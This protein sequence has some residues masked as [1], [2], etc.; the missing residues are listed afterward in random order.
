MIPKEKFKILMLEKILILSAILCFLPMVSFSQPILENESMLFYMN[1][2]LR[3]DIVTFGNVVGLDNK[4]KDDRSTYYGI[5]YSL[6][7]GL[8]FKKSATKLYLKLER[9]GPYDYDAP[10]FVH[11]TLMTSGGVIERYRGDELLPQVEEFWLDAALP[12][13]LKF[14]AGLYNHE[15]GNNFSLC[16][17]YENYGFT[18]YK[19][20]PAYA[21]KL[22]YF[23]PDLV[24]KNHLGPQ[25]HQDREQDIKYNHNASNFFSLDAKFMR[26]TSSLWPY[27]GVLTDYTSSG[28]RDNSFTAPTKKDI[29]GTLGIAWEF[30]QEKFTFKTEAARNFGKAKSQD[31][32]YKDVEHTGYFIYTDLDYNLGN[33]TPSFSCLVSS[34]N[35][36]TPEM[37]INLDSTLT[38]GKNRAFS[39]YSPLNKNFGDSVSHNHG[40]IRPIVAAGAGYGLN[41]GLPRPGTFSSGDLENLIMPSLGFDY[42]FTEKL[43]FGLF[44]YYLNAFARPVGILNTEGRYLSREL[45]YEADFFIDYQHNKNIL[46]SLFGGYFIPGKYYKE[47]REDTSGSLFNPY[48]R[49]DGGADAAYQIE[50]CLEFKY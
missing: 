28:K 27:V 22:H 35:K 38:S 36:V 1:S 11:N 17:G 21:V 30:K 25:V 8:D 4:N 31:P 41:Y 29:L 5:D 13:S 18:L 12:L 50:W 44:A 40:D 10:I 23:R 37:A 46:V 7:W 16:G 34:G 14:K 6:G 49:G 39:V 20:T 24:Y 47:L 9:N 33:L 42:K 48:V 19:E 2:Y 43:N 26:G 45:G 3:Q 15:V 32:A